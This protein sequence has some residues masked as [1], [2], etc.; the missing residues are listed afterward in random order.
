MSEREKRVMAYHQEDIEDVQ[1]GPV[2]SRHRHCWHIEHCLDSFPA[3]IGADDID[4]TRCLLRLSELEA[5]DTDLDTCLAQVSSQKH[6]SQ[7]ITIKMNHMTWH[8][9]GRDGL[10]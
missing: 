10:R 2:N 1:E 9:M 4:N 7:P 6:L 3:S 5:Q 8:G